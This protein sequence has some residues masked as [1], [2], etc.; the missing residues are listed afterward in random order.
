MAPEST[1]QK[2]HSDLGGSLNRPPIV[3]L[4]KEKTNPIN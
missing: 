4:E 2:I 1:Q 3:H